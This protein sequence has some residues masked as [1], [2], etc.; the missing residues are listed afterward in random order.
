MNGAARDEWRCFFTLSVAV[1]LV[2]LRLYQANFFAIT[3][4]PHGEVEPDGSVAM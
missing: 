4:W 2:A 3:L 1:L